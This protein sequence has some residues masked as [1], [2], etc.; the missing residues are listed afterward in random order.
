[1]NQ[2]GRR[3]YANALARQLPLIETAEG[4]TIDQHKFVGS[5]V[6]YAAVFA[7]PVSREHLFVAISASAKR[8][9]AKNS[10]MAITGRYQAIVWQGSEIISIH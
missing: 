6:E 3:T 1:M 8:W 2:S 9:A 10:D 5:N 4:A 7:C